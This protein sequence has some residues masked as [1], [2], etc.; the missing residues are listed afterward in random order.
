VGER[1]DAALSRML[2]VSRTKV[3]EMAAAG[4]ILLGGRP[5]DKSDR[6]PAGGVL[7]VTIPEERRI[8]VLPTPV[9]D[10]TILYEDADI[11][12]IDK[13]VGVAAHASPGW[14]GPTVLGALLAAGYPITTSGAA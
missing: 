4:L 8:E 6:L 3:G 2:G 5:L 14:E 9:E 12:V 10:F 7:D 11:I 13:P 1:V